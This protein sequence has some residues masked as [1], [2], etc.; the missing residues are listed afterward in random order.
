MTHTNNETTEI[1]DTTLA[2]IQ[3]PAD[4]ISV[5]DEAGFARFRQQAKQLGFDEVIVRR[6]DPEVFIDTHTHS[7]KVQ[8]V[9]VEGSMLLSLSGAACELD[10]GSK[11]SLDFDTP[12]AERYGPKGAVY[13]VARRNQRP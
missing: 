6:W 11:F 12:H 4:G 5:F 9:V 1:M 13:W 8:A 2:P 3:H 7:F 10:A